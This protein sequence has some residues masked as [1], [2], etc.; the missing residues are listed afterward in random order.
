[1]L[2]CFQRWLHDLP[3]VRRTDTLDRSGGIYCGWRRRDAAFTECFPIGIS[4][5][6]T[7]VCEYVNQQRRKSSGGSGSGRAHNRWHD[8]PLYAYNIGYEDQ[9]GEKSSGIRR[10]TI[11][12]YS[13]WYGNFESFRFWNPPAC[14]LFGNH[15]DSKTER[16]VIT[17]IKISDCRLFEFATRNHVQDKNQSIQAKWSMINK[18]IK[19]QK[20]DMEL[21]SNPWQF[22][23]KLFSG[24]PVLPLLP[25]AFLQF[26]VF[27]FAQ[28][29]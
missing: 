19:L 18:N 9:C 5:I 14:R 27:F 7:F 21:S 6:P 11:A 13:L 2:S 10:N 22:R 26:F 17:A 25:S 15:F 23:S 28:F 8:S 3:E 29:Y 20:W 24:K 4:C 16:G 1:M 12:R